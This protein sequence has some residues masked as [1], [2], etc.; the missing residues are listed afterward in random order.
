MRIH[1]LSLQG[2]SE[3]F[4]DRISVDFEALGPGLIAIVGENGA[5]KSTL[6]GAVFAALFR[7]LPGQK[8]PL[9]DFCTHSEPEIDMTFGVNG[10]RFR[11]LLKLDP[12][13]RQMES[14]IFD[15]QGVALASGK[16][17]AFAEWT[18]K[19]VGS[20]GGFLA[21]IFSSQR[22]TGNFLSLERSQRKEL[23]VTQLLGLERL[24]LISATARGFADEENKKVLVLEG[25][26]KGI[27]QVL[28][29]E[30]EFEDVE[31]LGLE[32]EALGS[33]LQGLEAQKGEQERRVQGLQGRESERRAL[34]SQRQELN[35][36]IEKSKGEIAQLRNQIGEDERLL[37]GREGLN[38]FRERERAVGEKIAQL[39]RQIAETQMLEV[40]NSEAETALRAVEADMNLKRGDLNR[41]RAE[42]EELRS[43]PCGG[44]G[45]YAG[46]VKIRRA[47]QAR[48]QV[49]VMQGEVS[50]LELE[51]EAQRGSLVTIP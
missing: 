16:K 51:L 21:S 37:A 14:Y 9:Y 22:R 35:R 32:L 44:Q 50:T 2:I 3:A 40:S 19:H 48:Q 41:S 25:E 18:S 6:I 46:C 7:Q 30:P 45:P 10:G 39:H 27:S 4:R 17:E 33:R 11:S 47:I 23:F 8:R 34:E 49:P 24:R 26:K 5:G 15:H 36:R 20:A 12:K 1:Q 42:S 28:A 31:T 13:A 43:V 29:S 38:G